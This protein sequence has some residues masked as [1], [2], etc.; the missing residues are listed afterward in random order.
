MK[1]QKNHGTTCTNAVP[2]FFVV[3]I[4]FCLAEMLQ[5]LGKILHKLD[6]TEIG[7]IRIVDRMIPHADGFACNL[8]PNGHVVAALRFEIVEQ[9]LDGRDDLRRVAVVDRTSERELRAGEDFALVLE[10]AQVICCVDECDVDAEERED[11]AQEDAAED[12]TNVE[13]LPTWLKEQTLLD[14]SSGLTNCGSLDDYLETMK[15]F[16]EAYTEN[17]K[18]IENFYNAEDWKNYTIRVHALKSSARIIGAN[19]LGELAA[20]LEAAGNAGDV[21][22]IQAETPRLFDLYAACINVLQPVAPADTAEETSDAK[23]L[24]TPEELSEVYE[25]LKE[26]AATFDYDSAQF[27]LEDIA[28]KEAPESERDHFHAVCQA[29][30]KPDWMALQNLLNE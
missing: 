27:V 17:R 7:A 22:K 5:R 8:A 6:R 1:T 24:L 20:A 13:E 2:W 16:A 29:A 10:E 15:L 23:E 9:M 21:A 11:A 28:G 3:P 25:A 30:K 14:T 12:A 4:L 26:V 18:A 19:E